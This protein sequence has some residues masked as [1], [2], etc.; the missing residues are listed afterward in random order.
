MRFEERWSLEKPLGLG[1]ARESY[2][3][4]P[5]TVDMYSLLYLYFQD[6]LKR[7]KVSILCILV[8]IE[9]LYNRRDRE[10]VQKLQLGNR[11]NLPDLV[12]EP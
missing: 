3:M 11:A 6:M 5:L 9:R 2:V 7:L 8:Q 4:G 10:L 1:P 12:V